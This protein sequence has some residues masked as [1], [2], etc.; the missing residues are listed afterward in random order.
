MPEIRSGDLRVAFDAWGPESSTHAPVVMLHGNWSSRGWWAPTAE[1]LASRL[2]A[3]RL[4]A[5]DSRGRGDTRGP[6]HGHR[7]PELAAD[8][9]RWLD[10]LGHP[11]V[12]LV[13]HSLGSAVAMELAR[14]QG[15]RV[16]SLV[17]VGP[18]WVDG[19][20]PNLGSEAAHQRLH[21]E[22]DRLDQA[23]QLMS[24]G[25]VRDAR[26]TTLVAIARRQSVDATMRTL[27]GLVAW[28]PGD[29]LR[30]LTMPRVVVHGELDPLCGGATAERA[31]EA[32]A[33]ERIEL[34]GIG[35]SPNLEAP[36]VLAEVVARIVRSSS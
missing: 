23:L 28:R 32:M 19:M 13:G 35:H 17:V 7:I 31:A 30:T 27:A 16:A 6:D 21:D 12:H 3:H 10:A 9:L 22:P 4:L 20:P 33:C 1:A 15:S 24:P 11:F 18:A 5:P 14:A 29:T 36:R 25:I 2:P 8:V 34:P 26:W